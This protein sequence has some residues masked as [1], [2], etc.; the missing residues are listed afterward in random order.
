MKKTVLFMIFFALILRGVTVAQNPYESIGK[1]AKVLTLS[2]GKYQEIFTND[3]I[4]PIGSVMYNRVTG[5]IVAFLTRDT[6]YAEYNL[7]PEVVSRWLSPDPL[8]AKFPQWSPYNYAENNPILRIDP[9]GGFSIPIHKDITRI[10]LS[11]IAGSEKY[12]Q[13]LIGANARTDIFC[14]QC[15]AHFDGRRTFSD[16][17]NTWN[18]LNKS[19][20]KTGIGSEKMGKILHTAQDFYSHSNYVELYVKFYKDNGGDMAKLNPKNIPTYN[21]AI[22]TGG[23]FVEKYLKSET[24]GLK[25]GEYNLV[26]HILGT[27]VKNAN[28]EGHTHHDQMNKDTPDKGRGS[29]SVEGTDFK[30]FDLAKEVATKETENIVRQKVEE[31]KN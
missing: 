9:N 19:I 23:D 16:V 28:E 14:S 6:M 21:E 30:W 11:R 22:K 27:D 29:E 2:N 26:P 20:S 15:N 1:K 18:D 3:T 13:R 7:E 4:V 5:D 17:N 12:S 10:A 24:N 31:K 8:G 25:T